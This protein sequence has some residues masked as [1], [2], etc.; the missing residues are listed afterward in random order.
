VDT[1]AFLANASHY[2]VRSGL[3]P[4]SEL[5]CLAH[6]SFSQK[7]GILFSGFFIFTFTQLPLYKNVFKILKW[8]TYL[9]KIKFLTL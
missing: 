3:S 7:P 8:K 5:T 6:K 4:Y 1:L 9:K 2:Q